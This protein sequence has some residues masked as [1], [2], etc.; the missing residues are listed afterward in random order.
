MKLDTNM[1]LE[2]I[3]TQYR[4]N[5]K[6]SRM[7]ILLRLLREILG[8]SEMKLLNKRYKKECKKLRKEEKGTF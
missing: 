2:D 6:Q 4:L 1:K 5:M 8:V 3:N 7:L